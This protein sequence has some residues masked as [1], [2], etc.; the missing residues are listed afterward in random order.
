MEGSHTN[1]ALA[2]QKE[3][4]KVGNPC[5]EKKGKGV[6]GDNSRPKESQGHLSPK[7]KRKRGERRK[8]RKGMRS[9][10]GDTGKIDLL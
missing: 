4:Q 2:R 7:E 6:L 5:I 3:V 1:S 9:A 8:S 10:W